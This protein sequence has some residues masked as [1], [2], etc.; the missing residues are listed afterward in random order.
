MIQPL[1]NPIPRR[2]SHVQPRPLTPLFK[3]RAL[4]R[5]AV[6]TQPFVHQ[7]VPSLAKIWIG[8]HPILPS[9]EHT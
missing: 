7:S 4:I 3:E 9:L 8:F 5:A 6:T 2:V 1:H